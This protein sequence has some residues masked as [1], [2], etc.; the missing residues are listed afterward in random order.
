MIDCLLEA[1]KHGQASKDALF[2]SDRQTK[3]PNSPPY[4]YR[5]CPITEFGDREVLPSLI[6]APRSRP[7]LQAKQKRC[8]HQEIQ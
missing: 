5:M 7:T 4:N 6:R 3:V 2:P 1:D 8:T